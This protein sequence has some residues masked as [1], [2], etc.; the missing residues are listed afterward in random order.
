MMLRS[1]PLVARI[2]KTIL[3]ST[4]FAAATFSSS[5]SSLRPDQIAPYLSSTRGWKH[6]DG[7][8]DDA[9]ASPSKL[10]KTFNFPDFVAAF[11]FM[12]RTALVAEKMD[13]HPEWFNVYNRVEVTLT[14]HDIG[15]VSQ[16]DLELGK[17]GVVK[18]AS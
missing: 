15:G 4:S 11:A 5:S 13:H 18:Q 1:A 7:T 14:S 10:T 9:S 16:R 2:C 12:T 17:R 6:I 3:S 8:P